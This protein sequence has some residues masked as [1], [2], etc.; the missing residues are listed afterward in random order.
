[1]EPTRALSTDSMDFY[2]CCK[3]MKETSR[4]KN[5][6]IS[7]EREETRRGDLSKLLVVRIEM[8]LNRTTKENQRKRKT[9]K[10]RRE[11]DSE[12]HIDL[13]CTN[14]DGPLRVV[15]ASCCHILHLGCRNTLKGQFSVD[16]FKD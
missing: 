2:I 16:F 12:A 14:K 10:R 5:I 15:Y 1:M 11:P 4:K 6:Y 3:S 9:E 13:Q 7:S 8:N